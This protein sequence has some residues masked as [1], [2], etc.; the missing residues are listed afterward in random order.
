MDNRGDTNFNG[1]DDAFY[2]RVAKYL[3]ARLDEREF[4]R[5]E[6]ELAGD[7]QKRALFAEICLQAA[8]I[9]E[10]GL[11]ASEDSLS[12]ACAAEAQEIPLPSVARPN[13]RSRSRPSFLRDAVHR[14][15]KKVGDLRFNM[16]L[17]WL[18]SLSFAGAVAGTGAIITAVL[19]HPRPPEVA[20]TEEGEANGG[21]AGLPQPDAAPVA[22]LVRVVDCRWSKSTAPP[23]RGEGLKAGRKLI[24]ESGLAEIVFNNGAETILEGPATM[25]IRSPASAAL[26]RGKLAVTADKPSA[27]GFEV[28]AP[29]MKYTDLGTEFGVLVAPSGEQQV[30]VFRGRVTAEQ[31]E[32]MRDNGLGMKDGGQKGDSGGDRR[33][34]PSTFIPHPSSVVLTAHE[35]IRVAAPAVPGGTAPPIQHIAADE[36]QFVRTAQMTQIAAQPPEFRRWKR[37]SD[38]LCKRQDLVAYYD[39]QPDETDRTALR[40]RAPAHNNSG[41]R[42]LDGRIEGAKWTDGHIAGKRGLRFSGKNDRV[43]VTIPGKFPALT[44]VAW[45]MV[46]DLPHSF[47]AILM[48]D[49][50]SEQ[51]GQCHW[52]ILGD[53]TVK[54]GCN[55]STDELAMDWAVKPVLQPRDRRVWRNLAMTYDS[56]SRTAAVYVDG[57]AIG[58]GKLPAQ[59]PLFFGPSQIANWEPTQ[60]GVPNYSDRN[61]PVRIDEMY[62]LNRSLSAEEIKRLYESAVAGPGG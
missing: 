6:E 30:H 36:K 37:F 53:G 28:V 39:F 52:Q 10:S 22:R 26:G 47:N 20:G 4:A 38:E 13:Q 27:H 25:E 56:V 46:E 41:G 12:F 35:A 44:A 59:I 14:T 48:S 16:A 61:M 60:P 19:M 50:W 15:K 7:G 51:P 32:S 45:L 29:G 11:P 8:V 18:L 21:Q 17:G 42:A 5:F 33:S 9:A 54:L 23:E 62:L 57:R 58:T 31:R 2:E 40:N 1:P 34:N 3:D 49:R 43:R 55:T 24:L